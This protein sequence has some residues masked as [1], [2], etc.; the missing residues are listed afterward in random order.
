MFISGTC[1]SV[2]DVVEKAGPLA[3]RGAFRWL[4]Q[5]IARECL[6][7]QGWREALATPAKQ[8]LASGAQLEPAPLAL[9]AWCASPEAA[10][11]SLSADRSD[12][13]QLARQPLT[14]LVPP[15]RVPTAFL[16]MALGLNARTHAGLQPVVNSFFV[17]HDALASGDY[18][19]ESWWLLS[20]QLPYLGIWRDWDRCEKL[21]RAAREWLEDHVK[22]GNPLLATAKSK[23]HRALAKRVFAA[24]PDV[25]DHID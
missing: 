22:S 6:P 12:I 25:N 10:A 13:Q 18:S 19:S 16:L 21:R 4:D 8:M 15:L 20:P 11:R 1:V 5:E 7:S 3:M 9:C 23:E 17:V 2:R 24:E 14:A